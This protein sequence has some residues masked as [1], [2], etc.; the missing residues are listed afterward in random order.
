MPVRSD[1]V[2]LNKPNGGITYRFHER[3]LYLVVGQRPRECGCDS[4]C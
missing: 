2:M 3:D 4:A 1:E